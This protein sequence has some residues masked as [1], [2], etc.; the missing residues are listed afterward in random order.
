VRSTKTF[1]AVVGYAI[2]AAACS[3]GTESI[4]M[5]VRPP[6]GA[7][8]NGFSFPGP[9]SNPEAQ[10]GE[11]IWHGTL[12][13]NAG[14]E[15]RKVIG[16]IEGWAGWANGWM[17]LLT[18]RGHFSGGIARNVV[19]PELAEFSVAAT[20]ITL[21]GSSWP[22]GSRVDEFA[23]SGT[24]SPPTEI[25]LDFSGADEIG[26]V[27]MSFDPASDRG[28]DLKKLDG[29]WVLRDEFENISATFEI[30]SGQNTAGLSGTGS[31]D[32]TDQD[33]CVYTGTV[34][35]DTWAYSVYLYDVSLTIS[36]CPGD[37]GLD[38]NGDY[39]GP[40]GLTDLQPGSGENDL[41]II[42]ASNMDVGRAVT[43]ALEKI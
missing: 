30:R 13:W 19:S 1:L 42:G 26:T 3:G 2:A 39:E 25:N 12:T 10:P 38:P 5:P 36:N 17:T 9:G 40:A 18:E 22:N 43:L 37:F 32:G 8:T 11:G 14:E 7:G 27:S 24:I 34:S 35:F 23:F 31:I 41:F 4:S 33:G 20:G 6:G 28:L 21:A 29:M 16:L 15:G